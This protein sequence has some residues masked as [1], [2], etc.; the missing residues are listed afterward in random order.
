MNA[1]ILEAQRREK[2]EFFR[3]H[4]MSPLSPEQQEKFT[5]LRYY[6]Y[7]AALDLRLPLEVFQTQDVITVET[8]S[9][10][11]RRY[12]RL[13]E[14]RFAVGDE[15]ARLTVYETP[16]GLFLP[17]VDAGINVETYGA[18]RYLEPE[19]LDD[20]SLHID[21][22]QAYNPYCAYSEGYSC[23]LT[24]QENR[25]NVSICAGEMLP[26]GDWVQAG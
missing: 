15:E 13:G 6:P 23:P 24:P 17:F 16:H 2:D 19:E 25:L 1:Q 14:I 4:P 26:E 22:N 21:F 9:G 8:S 10:E 7:N 3:T 18:G 12:R 20:G 5:Q 11:E